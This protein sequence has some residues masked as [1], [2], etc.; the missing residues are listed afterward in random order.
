MFDQSMGAY[1]DMQK[2]L[3][4]IKIGFSSFE[5]CWWFTWAMLNSVNFS[6]ANVYKGAV[7]CALKFIWG[8]SS[9]LVA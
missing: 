9:V 5:Y 3:L 8:Q 2:V 6:H 7:L 1:G 4:K